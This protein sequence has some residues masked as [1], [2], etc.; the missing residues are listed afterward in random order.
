MNV[1]KDI[2]LW[3]RT[4]YLDGY[5]D[6]QALNPS[7]RF[8]IKIERCEAAIE[9]RSTAMLIIQLD[10]LKKQQKVYNRGYQDG[11]KKRVKLKGGL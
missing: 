10:A 5:H 3:L 6:A 4:S 7:N 11:T 8:D 2:E 1:P 9:K